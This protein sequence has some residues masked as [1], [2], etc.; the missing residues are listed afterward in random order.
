MKPVIGLRAG[1]SLLFSGLLPFYMFRLNGV[2][3]EACFALR[4]PLGDDQVL[5]LL[6]TLVSANTPAQWPEDS[7]HGGTPRLER[8]PQLC[9]RT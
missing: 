5:S 9:F 2:T 7:K 6:E 1:V 3:E 8:R 4:V